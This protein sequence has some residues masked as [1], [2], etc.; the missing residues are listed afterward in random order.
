MG[1]FLGSIEFIFQ[2]VVP[3][4]AVWSLE[5]YL[6][7]SLFHRYY[8]NPTSDTKHLKNWIIKLVS[9]KKSSS[10]SM[11]ESASNP[12]NCLGSLNLSEAS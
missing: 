2:V 8:D 3:L 12:L 9:L 1:G 4:V 5:K 7:V 10:A 11:T 6:I